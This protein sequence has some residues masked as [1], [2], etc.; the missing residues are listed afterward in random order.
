MRRIEFIAPVASMR[1][2]LSGSQELKY[3]DNVPAWYAETGAD[4]ENYV[5]RYVGAKRSR[6][7]HTYFA[8]KKRAVN[9]L[10]S[11]TRQWPSIM[12]YSASAYQ[13][14]STSARWSEI[15]LC[16]K[17]EGASSS[18]WQGKTASQLVR[19]KLHTLYSGDNSITIGVPGNSITIYS[20]Y[21]TDVPSGGIIAEVS[22]EIQSKFGQY[23][24]HEN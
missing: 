9:T 1:G 23:I 17:Y 13:T 3:P 19:S 15:I 21:A 6:D 14:L 12:A 10:S 2:N 4:A 8:V 22:N 5:P 16:A 24:P 18:T 7:G 11:G 20:I